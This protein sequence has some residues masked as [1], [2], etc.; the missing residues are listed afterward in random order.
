MVNNYLNYKL[1]SFD[2]TK[3]T[4]FQFE[5]P[6]VDLS[7]LSKITGKDLSVGAVNV[8]K[9]E[10][11][12]TVGATPTIT[13]ASTPVGTTLKVYLLT[14]S[15]DHGTVQTAGTPSS[16]VNTYSIASGVITLN[17]TTAPAGTQ[18]IVYYDYAAGSTTQTVT[19]TADKFPPYMKIV[20]EGLVTDQVTGTDTVPVKFTILKAKPK[21][22][23]SLTMKSTEATT[24]SMEFDL[25]AVLVGTEQVYYTMN[26]MA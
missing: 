10:V 24:L 18:I 8:P 25:F 11:L 20:G 9:R 16:T 3:S 4:T 22:N 17:A 19:M 13:L 14:A 5:A 12:T 23:F 1:V 6:L 15:R 2:H 26:I 7:F 21:N